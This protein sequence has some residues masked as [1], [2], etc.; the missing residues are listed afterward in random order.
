MRGQ[1]GV[2]FFFGHVQA[3]AFG[4]TSR[5]HPEHRAHGFRLRT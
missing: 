5:Q 4:L 2:E 1:E 3:L